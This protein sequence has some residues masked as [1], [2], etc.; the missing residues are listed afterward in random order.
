MLHSLATG[1]SSKHSVDLYMPVESESDHF[2]LNLQS[3]C[4]GL[5]Y[6]AD[7]EE[8]FWYSL[9]IKIKAYLVRENYMPACD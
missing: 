8:L 6:C 9:V 4:L 1:E 2:I 3:S 5:W 7:T